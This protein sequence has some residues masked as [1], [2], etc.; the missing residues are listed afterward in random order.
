MW[1]T[2]R[3]KMKRVPTARD[4]MAQQG[5]FLTGAPLGFESKLNWAPMR[6]RVID[7]DTL[8]LATSQ[9][10]PSGRST[11]Q[12]RTLRLHSRAVQANLRELAQAFE[13]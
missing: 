8:E 1:E 9:W 4:R 12:V 2:N 11:R 10:T 7:T 6:D 13:V 5:Y 3:Q